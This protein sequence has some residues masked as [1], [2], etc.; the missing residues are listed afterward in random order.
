MPTRT[1]IP[2]SD[3]EAKGWKA[4]F[5][6]EL[7]EYAW[8][9]FY[10]TIFFGLFAW[11]RRL[12]L[13]EYQ[14]TYWHY[15]T[16]FIEALILAKIVTVGSVL[17]FGRKLEHLSLVYPT[18]YKSFVFSLLV[19]V[20]GIVEHGVRGWLNG[21]GWSG[22]MTE[23]VNQGRYE[24]LAKCLVTFF[25]FIPFF[26]FKELGRALGRGKIQQLFLRRNRAIEP[27]LKLSE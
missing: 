26:A 23:L 17:R 2:D 20:F 19:A 27:E 25:A 13:A 18:L 3:H 14:I 11:Y 21:E 15:G 24:L 6:R 7:G 22:G 16:A 8:N 4:K 1:V 5:G 9:V 12:I 10:L